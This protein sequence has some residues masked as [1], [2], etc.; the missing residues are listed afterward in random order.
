MRSTMSVAHR[1]T[2][3]LLLAFLATFAYACRPSPAG[4]DAA[5]DIGPAW[6][7]ATWERI[8]SPEQIGWSSAKL[9]A[10]RDYAATVH[11]DAVIIV[12]GGKVLAEWGATTKKLR[13]HSIRK[14]LLSALYGIQVAEG[15]IDL[16]RTLE[17]LGIDDNEPSLDAVEKQAT[18]R[19]L[20]EA[21]SGVYH[22]ALY[23]PAQQKAGLPPRHSHAPGTFWYYNNWDFN[24]LGTIY[25]HAAKNSIYRDFKTRIAEPLEME[26]Y[27]VDDGEYVT[28]PD[29]VHAAYTFRMTA[30]DLARFGLLYLRQGAWKGKQIIPRAWVAESL[31]LASDIGDYHG[32]GGYGYLW[33]LAVDGKHLPGITVPE[34]TF[35]ARGM[36]GHYLLVVPAYDLVVVHRVD[37]DVPDRAVSM[38]E[39]S[40]LV[41]LIF[42]ARP[43]A[44]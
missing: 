28:G 42:E 11:T 26:D 16:S 41:K 33:W 10:A 1:A 44:P 12:V 4:T 9:Q 29:S 36:G 3:L 2:P 38:A 40:T 37:T 5:A 25:E 8:A 14:S 22:P 18:V 27:E 13:L 21:R 39:F 24:A 34:G 20:L 30:R 19:E 23:A 43:H 35:S 17:S 6:P 31:R 15:R 32:G 7:G